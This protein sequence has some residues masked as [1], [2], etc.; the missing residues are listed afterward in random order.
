MLTRWLNVDVHKARYALMK[1]GAYDLYER[2]LE[3]QVREKPMPSHIGIILDGN[4]R[5]ARMHGLKPWQGHRA[6]AKRVEELLNWCLEL[7]IRTITLYAFSTENFKRS[8]RE[9]EELMKLFKEELKRLKESDVIRKHKVRVKVIGRLE[10]LPPDVRELA[11]EVEEAT[12]GYSEHYLNIAIAYGGRAEI[13]DAVR[14][15]ARDVKAGLIEPEE[16]DEELF[17]SYLYT[18]HLPEA[19]KDPDL[20]IRTSGEE[21]LSGFLLWQS[22]YSE[23]CFID[24]LWPEFRRIDLLRAIR[25]YQGRQRRFGR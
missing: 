18:S 1:M 16:I 3:L 6:G 11:R 20:I 10:L 24:V 8:K 7:G 9:V 2:W 22:A 15:V 12:K 19:V 17:E 13:V 4:R 5:W 14:K 21:R 23:L 25:T